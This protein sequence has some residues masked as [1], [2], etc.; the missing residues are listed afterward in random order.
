MPSEY[1]DS[2]VTRH[3]EIKKKPSQKLKTLLII[4]LCLL[5][6]AIFIKLNSNRFINPVIDSYALSAKE[7]KVN[8]NK[9]IPVEEIKSKIEKE[10]AQAEGT[11]SIYFYDL[12]TGDNFGIN[13]NMMLMAASV[14]KIPILAASY[15][16][17]GKGVID[18]DKIIVPQTK[19]IQDYGTGSIRYDKPGTAYSIRTLARLMMEKSDNTAAYLLASVIVGLDEVQKLVTDWGMLQTDMKEN[20]T[21]VKDISKVL[22]KMYQGE[23]TSP[24]LSREMLDFMDDSDYEDR[25]PKGVP[26]TITVYH[27]TGDEVR[28]IHDA[29]IIVLPDR[30]YYLGIM[31]TDV[32]DAEV[33]KSK[34]ARIS[35]I[36][37]SEVTKL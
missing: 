14:N 17:A 8:K 13:D 34:M 3:L 16:F 33:T 26:S 20:K 35:Q 21:S 1:M 30:P 36:V 18:L 24:E 37:F 4:L 23:I 28:T 2:Y 6:I 31:T 25:I 5:F 7:I 27:K 22:K 32:A 12:T 19:D 29:G 10:L 15:Y 11:Y 9:S